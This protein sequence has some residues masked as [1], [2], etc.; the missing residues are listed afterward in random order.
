MRALRATSARSPWGL[1]GSCRLL[2]PGGPQLRSYF[3]LLLLGGPELFSRAGELH[4]NPLRL[5]RDSVERSAHAEVRA[6]R[7]V[8]AGFA[9]L[10][11]QLFRGLRRSLRLLADERVDIPVADR[12]A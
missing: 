6:K 3:V 11:D 9:D 1:A 4:R 7:V 10:A 8:T 5:V 12:D 2:A